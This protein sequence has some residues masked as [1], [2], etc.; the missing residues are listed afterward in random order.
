MNTQ[1][2]DDIANKIT[3]T[4]P[5]VPSGVKAE[6]EQSVQAILHNAFDKLELVTREDFEVQSAVLQKTR[7]KLEQ[8]EKKLS[9]F[10]SKLDIN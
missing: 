2:F 8:L 3:K 9:E 5:P 1:F 7:L 4:L 6:L 10:E